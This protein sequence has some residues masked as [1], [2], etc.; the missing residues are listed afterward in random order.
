MARTVHEIIARFPERRR[1]QIAKRGRELI[2]EEIAARP[3]AKRCRWIR[4]SL[5]SPLLATLVVASFFAGRASHERFPQFQDLVDYFRWHRPWGSTVVDLSED[6]SARFVNRG[7]QRIMVMF[8]DPTDPKCQP[9]IEDYSSELRG[10][11]IGRVDILK[12][13]RIARKY[14]IR[15]TPEFVIFRDGEDVAMLREVVSLDELRRLLNRL[16]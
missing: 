4:F 9:I 5:R 12:E 7:E 2:A 6:D 10:A 1:E 13:T 14:N 15:T 16:P 11:T 3:H 8:W